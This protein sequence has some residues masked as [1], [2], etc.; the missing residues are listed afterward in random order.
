M[1]LKMSSVTATSAA[2]SSVRRKRSGTPC[3]ICVPVLFSQDIPDA[4]DGVD[5]AGGDG[6][7]R[8][9]R[10]QL[11]AKV[12]DVDLQHVGLRREVDAPDTV[13]QLLA[14]QHLPRMA[15]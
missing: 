1:R 6:A 2:A 5:Q 9:G 13:E 3:F 4:A 7:V 10:F 11:G 12:A 14:G 8:Q 15:Q